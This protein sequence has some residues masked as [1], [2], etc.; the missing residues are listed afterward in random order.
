MK[1]VPEAVMKKKLLL[2]GFLCMIFILSACISENEDTGKLRIV[3]TIFAPYDFVREIA[4]DKVSLTMLLSPGEESHSFDPSP[5][6]IIDI[7]ECDLFIYNGG[8]NDE[9]A[10]DILD[11]VSDDIHVLKMMDCI[12]TLYT[13]EDEEHSHEDSEYDEHVWTSPLNAVKIVNA[14]TDML[15]ELD[16]DNADFYYDNCKRYEK[17]LKALDDD[18]RE[19][20]NGAKRNKIVFGDRFALRYFTEEFGISYYAAFPGCAQDTEI[21]P[22]KI[23]EIIDLVKKENIPVVFKAELSNGKIADTIGEASGAEVRTFYSCH[24]ISADDFNK[25]LGYTD[26]MERNMN[27]LKEALN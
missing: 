12:D 2:T 8:E 22:A 3:T 17:E 13:E 24:N 18:I 6:D 4:G 1:D 14:I 5:Q 20:V 15:A 16:G 25:G 27:L 10:D 9:W 26:M 11:S 21:N 23:T 19:V 7:S